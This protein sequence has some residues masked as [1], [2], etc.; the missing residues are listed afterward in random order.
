MQYLLTKEEYDALKSAEKNIP[1]DQLKLTMEFVRSQ[2]VG[3]KCIHSKS[4]DKLWYCGDCPISHIGQRG[5]H[6]SKEIS[7]LICPLSREYAQ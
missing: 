7:K 4:K 1:P 2:I 6:P 5:D 3:D